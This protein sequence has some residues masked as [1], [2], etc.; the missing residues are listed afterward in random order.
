M[1]KKNIVIISWVVSFCLITTTVIMLFFQGSDSKN[2]PRYN[3]NP[4]ISKKVVGSSSN[5][6]MSRAMPQRLDDVFAESTCVIIG[7]VLE[8]DINDTYQ[9]GC[10]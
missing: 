4:D 3:E 10:R 2:Q 1:K 5:G 9:I 6:F 7:E 8:D